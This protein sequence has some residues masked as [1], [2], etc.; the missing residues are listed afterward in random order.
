[1]TFAQLEPVS[2]KRKIVDI[3]NYNEFRSGHKGYD[4]WRSG[5]HCSFLAWKQRIVLMVPGEK[6]P[7]LR[8]D[9]YR[10]IKTRIV[11]PEFAEQPDE[12]SPFQLNIHPLADMAI[13]PT[14]QIGNVLADTIVPVEPPLAN[15]EIVP[16]AEFKGR[17]SNG[18]Y[19]YV[20]EN[21]VFN[22]L[23]GPL[24]RCTVK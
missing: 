2:R 24:Y 19:A 10:I 8:C 7:C 6:F 3:S 11:D 13:Q 20:K 5:K 23:E 14:Q 12:E 22:H 17:A 18:L 9:D 15:D 16:A 1:M 4:P 21:P